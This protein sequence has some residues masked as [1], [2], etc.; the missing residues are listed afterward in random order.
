MDSLPEE[1]EVASPGG[2]AP[3]SLSELN[4]LVEAGGVTSLRLTGCRDAFIKTRTADAAVRA[5]RSCYCLLLGWHRRYGRRHE[6]PRP[7]VEEH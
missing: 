2:G 3:A 6:M 1:T 7:A 4:A 5:V